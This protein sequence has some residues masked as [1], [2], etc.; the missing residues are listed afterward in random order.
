LSGAQANRR[1]EVYLGGSK[2]ILHGLRNFRTDTVTLNQR[3]CVL[4]LSSNI[5]RPESSSPKVMLNG[6]WKVEY[7]GGGCHRA[8]RKR[9][10]KVGRGI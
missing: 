8:R 6:D 5:V 3:D 2:D 9:E 4:S 1:S 7:R 10:E